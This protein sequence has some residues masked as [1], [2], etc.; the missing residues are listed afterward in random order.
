MH[1]SFSAVNENADEN[2]IPFS[3]EKRKRK[4]CA[5]I[6][7][8]RYGSVANITF[9]AQHKWIFL[10]RKRKIKQKWKFIFG[11][12]QKSRKWPNRPFSAP[13]TKASF[14]RLLVWWLDLSDSDPLGFYD[15]STPLTKNP[16]GS[17]FSKIFFE[18]MYTGL[19]VVVH[20]CFD[21]SL[22]RQMAPQ[23]SSKFRTAFLVNFVPVWGTIASPIMHRF[24]RCFWNLLQ[25]QMCFAT[26]Y[27]FRTYVCRWRHKVRK[28]AV[29]F[30]KA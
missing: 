27:A 1:F 16:T 12:K 7:E 21:F 9:S 17:K 13:K 5:D 26:H 23:Q 8:L 15:R 22:W 18:Q 24:G 19:I 3:A 2:E 25:D 30:G 29:E 28:I 11:R 6:T 14:G 4:T 20:Q 10:E